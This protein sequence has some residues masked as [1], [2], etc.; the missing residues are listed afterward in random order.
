MLCDTNLPNIAFDVHYKNIFVAYTTSY[1]IQDTEDETR[2]MS[3][4]TV[5]SIPADFPG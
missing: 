3:E 2:E 5:D 4:R 1:F